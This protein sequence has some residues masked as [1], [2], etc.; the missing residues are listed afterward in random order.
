MRAVHLL[1][2]LLPSMSHE[3]AVMATLRGHQ[4]VETIFRVYFIGSAVGLTGSDKYILPTSGNFMRARSDLVSIGGHHPPTCS[5]L[6][7]P[8]G[9][10]GRSPSIRSGRRGLPASRQRQ[11]ALPRPSSGNRHERHATAY[12]RWRS[13]RNMF[14]VA[15]GTCEPSTHRREDVRGRQASRG[16]RSKGGTHRSASNRYRRRT[17]CARCG[18]SAE[19]R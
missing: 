11:S 8:H 10:R 14:R 2:H 12:V 16:T 3:K 5:H 19:C 1:R 6:P 7:R 15:E 18:P 17:A 4:V 13:P 9:S